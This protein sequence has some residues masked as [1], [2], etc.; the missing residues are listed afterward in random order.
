MIDPENVPAVE[1][2]ELLARYVLQSS[3]IRRSDQT[4][5]PDAFLP[6]PHRDLSVTRHRDAT[7][8]ELWEVGASVANA[9]GKKLYGRADVLAD[10]AVRQGLTVAAAPIPGNPNHADISNWPDDKPAQKIRA[11]EISASAQLVLLND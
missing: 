9:C 7:T 4:V 2:D 1:S 11:M 10:A 8:V 5:K 6:H 3:Y